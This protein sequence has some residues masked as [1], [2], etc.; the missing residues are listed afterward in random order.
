LVNKKEVKDFSG[1]GVS[2][3]EAISNEHMLSMLFYLL[4]LLPYLMLFYKKVTVQIRLLFISLL[5]IFSLIIVDTLKLT[6]PV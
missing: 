3:I 6:V 2:L 1:R 4:I 5:E